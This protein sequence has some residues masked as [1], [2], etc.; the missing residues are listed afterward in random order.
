MKTLVITLAG[1]G[2]IFLLLLVRGNAKKVCP[3]SAAVL[4][5]VA[6]K[7][8]ASIKRWSI[9]FYFAEA[10]KNLKNL[11]YTNQLVVTKFDGKAPF[12]QHEID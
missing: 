11:K 3:F 9:P 8:A 12:L 1:P 6:Y 2:L 5:C 4:V 10:K 7:C